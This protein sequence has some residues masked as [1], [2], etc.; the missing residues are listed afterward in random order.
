MELSMWMIAQALSSYP[1]RL[2]IAEG[3]PLIRG[4]RFLS[5]VEI[6]SPDMVY[7]EMKNECVDG[8]IE[9][10][11]RFFN[12]ND[13][14]L[15]PDGR[16]QE[17]LN[18][19]LTLFDTYNAWE[20][21]AEEAVR[22]S[23][24]LQTLL[25]AAA[26]VLPVRAWIVERGGRV[27]AALH[28]AGDASLF[29]RSERNLY[30]RSE[31][32]RQLSHRRS[33]RNAMFAV[34][35]LE[36]YCR[37]LFD[38]PHRVGELMIEMGKG[39]LEPCL[40]QL[41]ERIAGQIERWISAHAER[42]E[43]PKDCNVLQQLLLPDPDPA[44]LMDFEDFLLSQGWEPDDRKVL[45]LFRAAG[46]LSSQQAVEQ[47]CSALRG[48]V[49]TEYGS[50]A[51]LLV[52][53]TVC[54]EETVS[55]VLRRILSRGGCTAG[56][57]YPF[58]ELREVYQALQQAKLALET[59]EENPLRRCADYLPE[60]VCALI[61]SQ[62]GADLSHPALTVLEEYDEAH[63]TQLVETLGLYLLYE[64]NQK[65]TAEALELHRNSLFYRLNKIQE[66]C[67]L[68][69]DDPQTRLQL[70]L[71]FTLR[72]EGRPFAEDFMREEPAVY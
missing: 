63:R 1:C 33:A 37:D 66:L 50:R 47:D 9:R 24:S 20:E 65:I 31:F 58:E 13:S 28:R 42:G 51:A 21:H 61:R 53:L 60:Y 41:G 55:R 3:K 26:P 32:L 29:Y 68:D 22:G 48:S 17:V 49:L 34:P 11:V 7:I 72:S 12:Q 45:Y 27:C 8:G 30:M 4:A 16:Q 36:L 52:N 44:C 5:Q 71:S 54:G 25:D 18:E 14:I 6:P 15:V 39:G 38:G 43:L 70:L 40:M 35:E 2:H 23:A 59:E 57:S 62:T 56:V 64:R 69:L 46:A 10:E 67:G 19:L